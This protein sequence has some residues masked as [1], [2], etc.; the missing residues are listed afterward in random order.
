ML[1][2]LALE[3]DLSVGL[4]RN[5]HLAPVPQPDKKPRISP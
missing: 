5:Q 4:L 1:L 2:L 3:N